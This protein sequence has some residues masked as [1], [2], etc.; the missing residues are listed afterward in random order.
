MTHH[1]PSGNDL[2]ASIVRTEKRHSIFERA[3]RSMPISI[4]STFF[5]RDGKI[6]PASFRETG[7]VLENADRERIAA[8]FPKTIAQNRFVVFEGVPSFSSVSISG[9]RVGVLFS[10]GPAPG[11]HNVLAGLKVVLGKGNTLVGIRGGPKGLLDGTVVEVT[12]QDVRDIFNTGGFDFLGTDRTKI[13]S[14][15]QFEQVRATVLRNRMDGLVIVG[16]DDSNT[17]AAFIAEYFES[18]GVKCGVVGIPK[19]IDGDLAVGKLLPIS[20]G[21]DT[22]TKIYSELVGNLTR[23]R[24]PP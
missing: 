24:L 3:V 19:T 16:G 14:P 7:I 8:V 23:T 21:F 2:A 11:G 12:A 17:N 6:A 20:F 13:K 1:A 22:A 5:D 4:C 10:G 18:T 15:Q 9:K